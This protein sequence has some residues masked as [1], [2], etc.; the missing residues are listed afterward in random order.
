MKRP[1]ILGVC[2]VAVMGVVVGLL[3]HDLILRPHPL[4]QGCG[5]LA[6]QEL[7]KDKRM[8]EL[9]R[10]LAAE[11][12]N[13]FFAKPSTSTI[14]F[15]D[16]GFERALKDGLV[17]KDVIPATK[18]SDSPIFVTPFTRYHFTKKGLELLGGIAAPIQK[19][20]TDII[21][22]SNL[23]FALAAPIGQ[24]V[25]TVTGIAPSIFPNIIE[26]QVTTR[27]D[28]PPLVAQNMANYIELGT[29]LPAPFRK[30]DDGWRIE[31]TMLP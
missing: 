3:A 2:L 10:P 16:G 11:M 19:D 26:V 23:S 12:L 29:K 24:R 21:G 14:K 15:L 22:L 6:P 30:Y 27:Y 18:D 5:S 8:G 28:L 4:A 7:Q 13:E 20:M 31:T 17:E 25:D 1:K 9:T